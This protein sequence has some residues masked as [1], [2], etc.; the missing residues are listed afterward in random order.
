MSMN[1]T[2]LQTSN[3]WRSGRT[4]LI[5]CASATVV[6][7]T[8]APNTFAENVR[9]DLLSK[10]VEIYGVDLVDGG[11]SFYLRDLQT[12]GITTVLV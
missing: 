1:D 8:H 12:K 2:L 10:G 6:P 5:F 11:A 4:H 3:G 7:N 9:D